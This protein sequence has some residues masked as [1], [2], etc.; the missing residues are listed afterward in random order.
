MNKRQRKKRD[1]KYIPK[2]MRKFFVDDSKVMY[3]SGDFDTYEKVYVGHAG[4][5]V[6]ASR[7]F[8]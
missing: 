7:L 6:F 3:R 1:L 4:T 5:K 8:V 2:S